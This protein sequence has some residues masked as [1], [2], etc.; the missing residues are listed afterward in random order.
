MWVYTL[1]PKILN[2]S[3]TAGIVIVSVLIVRIPLKKAPR[4]FSYALW[5]VVLF[6]LVCPV[7][8]SS[9]LS[10]LGIF[11]TPAPTNN[12]IAYIPPDIVHTPS[13]QVDLP[14]PGISE[15]INRRL[16]QGEEQTVADPLEWRMAA[17]TIVWLSGMGAMLLY[18][19]ISLLLLRRK[20]IGAVHLRDNIYLADHIPTPFVLGMIRPKIFLPSIL[21]EQEQ[22]YILLHE[23]THI[24]RLDHVFKVAAFL[25]LTV[26]WFNPLVWA[27]FVTFTK[28]MEISCDE[29]VLRKMGGEIRQAYSS[30]LLSLA[31]GRHFINGSPLAFGE[32]NIK[33]RIRNAMGFKKPA[34]WVSIASL[35]LV[36]ALSIGLAANQVK[37]DPSSGW[38]SYQFPA[39]LYD[40][41]TL[42][43]EANVYP[44][45]F[46][47]IQAVL[48]NE[49]ME[50]SINCGL[51]FVLTKQVGD[52][53]RIVPFREDLA[54][55]EE[56]LPLPL[57][58][59]QTYRLTPDMLSVKLDA[60][61]YR[62]A[63]DIWYPAPELLPDTWETREKRTVWADFTITLPDSTGWQD[64]RI[65]MPLDDVHG[66]MGEPAGML[67]G[68]WGEIYP[69]E[70]GSQII[71]YYNSEALVSHIRLTQP[72]TD[73]SPSDS[74][75]DLTN[76]PPSASDEA[77]SPSEAPAAPAL[78]LIA[79]VDLDRDGQGDS[80]CLDRSGMPDEAYITL[81]VFND[82]NN[83]IWS[84]DAGLPHAGWQSLFLCKLDGEYY[85]LRYNPSMYQGSCYYYY[86]LFTLEGGQEKI[87]Q[88]NQL[89]FD[90]NGTKELD[91]PGM[92]AF[93]EEVNKLL[94]SSTLLMSTEGGHYTFGPSSSEDFFER[95]SWLDS[96]PK[97][98]SD[99]DSLETCL[100]IYSDYA[101]SARKLSE[102]Q[103]YLI[104]ETE[105]AYAKD[106][107][108]SYYET[109]V[110]KGQVTDIAWISDAAEYQTSILPHR[111]KDQVTAF[112]VTM[113]DHAVRQ[114]ILT[115]SKDGE[116]E[117]INEGV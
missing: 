23:Q 43:T 103:T 89:E 44:P 80:L 52:S 79:E 91:V 50:S 86:T 12:S 33:E 97:L 70:N 21:A 85:L 106:A 11:H 114:I 90:I 105:I 98:Y 55:T 71:I 67:F 58:S 115:K 108:L 9:E 64:I 31:T 34:M 26:H 2:M 37:S 47:A 1:L 22:S 101:L 87:I 13:P 116:W 66:I 45:S 30:S 18:S 100:S 20:L 48:T 93:A 5:A 69:L 17:A 84:Q 107:V 24:R 25:A 96:V 29:H 92:I 112:H 6:R 77:P 49:Q 83:E 36:A 62:I 82:N 117:V 14:L 104:T 8:F 54:F 4:I 72:P 59:S 57:G 75:K 15:A 51:A 109:T 3:L 73:A 88:S 102:E 94:D 60:G 81:R 95:Y 76:A 35:L 19:G 28:D 63:T 27:A 38:K 111:V 61:N 16:P 7:S 42:Q 78:E 10:L 99:N 39:L 65:G 46:E 53:W 113:S 32:G 74:G 40:R 41:V 68:F 56:A 110:F